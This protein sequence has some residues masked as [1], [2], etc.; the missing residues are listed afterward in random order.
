MLLL[1]RVRAE[2]VRHWIHRCSECWWCDLLSRHHG[3]ISSLLRWII[4]TFPCSQV[5]G[6]L[7][8]IVVCVVSVGF[9]STCL[10]V[11][12]GYLYL[13]ELVSHVVHVQLQSM[14]PQ[15]S[16]F[17]LPSPIITFVPQL[18]VMLLELRRLP[19]FSFSS[20]IQVTSYKPAVCCVP[21]DVI[22]YVREIWCCL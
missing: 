1:H 22:K 18:L 2:R 4:A 7:T 11:R 13:L 10:V 20:S 9:S 19:P 3:R 21:S 17:C 8:S 6:I 14:K 16:V 15:F 12:W 5:A